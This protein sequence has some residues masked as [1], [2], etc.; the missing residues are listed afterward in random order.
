MGF[1]NFNC[2]KELI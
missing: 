1:E 2:V